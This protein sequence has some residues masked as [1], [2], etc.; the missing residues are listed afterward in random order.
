MSRTLK[1]VPMD[2]SHPIGKVW[3]GYRMVTCIDKCAECQQFAFIKGIPFKDSGCPDFEQF[4]GPPIGGGYQ[5]WENV[6]DG[7]PYSPVFATLDELCE[8]CA[9]NATTFG[10]YKTNKEHWRQMLDD[11]F[12][13]QF[14]APNV[15]T[16]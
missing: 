9:I 12:V 11:D 10:H 2:F 14:I 5:L 15:I 3:H 7:S 1:R 4:I 16:F 13:Y 6:S 8:W